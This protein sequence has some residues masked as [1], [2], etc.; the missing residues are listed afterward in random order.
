M[1]IKTLRESERERERVKR[2][3]ER[4]R[5]RKRE[6]ERC[7]LLVLSKTDVVILQN[8]RVERRQ[9][10]MKIKYQSAYRMALV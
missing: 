9:W 10:I 4:E 6:R 5:E 8:S 7:Q 1:K 3:R 2:E